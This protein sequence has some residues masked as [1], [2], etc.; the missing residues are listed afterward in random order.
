[1]NPTFSVSEPKKPSAQYLKA[2]GK[3]G[4]ASDN[5]FYISS[6]VDQIFYGNRNH[7]TD[8]KQ[9]YVELD[10]LNLKKQTIPVLDEKCFN[11]LFVYLFD[12]FNYKHKDI[13]SEVTS[14]QKNWDNLKKPIESL[15][16]IRITLDI[17]M[18]SYLNRLL[19]T[20]GPDDLMA[21]RNCFDVSYS[22]NLILGKG[23]LT[24]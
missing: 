10:R 13:S 4:F 8:W 22:T 18:E 6:V 20:E 7:P 1:M 23:N 19:G 9:L 14:L 21:I 11:L 3:A 2:F 15:V 17:N 5:L 12:L 24:H 16:S